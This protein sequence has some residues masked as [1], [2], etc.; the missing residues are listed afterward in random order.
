MTIPVLR[1]TFRFQ[2]TAISGDVAIF[3]RCLLNLITCTD[4]GLLNT[5]GQTILDSIKIERVSVWS[6]LL[7]GDQA[8]YTS[9]LGLV[10]GGP[11][12]PSSKVIDVGN[13]QHMAHLSAR[14]PAQSAA[15][16]WSKEGQ[17]LGE[18]LFTIDASKGSILDIDVSYNY[19]NGLAS[20]GNTRSVTYSL[21]QAN[22]IVG[23]NALDNTTSSGTVGGQ[24][25]QPIER[26]Y[27]AA[28]G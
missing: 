11:Y 1:S 12:T 21:V 17:N 18:L 3:R 19:G 14:P 25:W 7:P 22:P 15:S 20:T 16:W 9:V 23:H 5:S 26:Y 2:A 28:F 24:I 4:G 10:W 8:L 13:P 6:P 27:A